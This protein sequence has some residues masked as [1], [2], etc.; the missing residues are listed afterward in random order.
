MHV[1]SL[2]DYVY[3]IWWVSSLW[4]WAIVSQYCYEYETVVSVFAVS[5]K[6]LY[7]SIVLSM[8][9]RLNIL[10]TQCLALLPHID[11]N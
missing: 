4:S 6:L 3:N 2:A 10:T 1:M 9:L 5:M 8:K 11:T 7:H